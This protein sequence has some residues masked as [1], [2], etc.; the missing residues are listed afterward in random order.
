MRTTKERHALEVHDARQQDLAHRDVLRTLFLKNKS[1]LARKQVLERQAPTA[2]NG[3]DFPGRNPTRLLRPHPLGCRW[4]ALVRVT[5]QELAGHG[6]SVNPEMI[7]R[8]V[9]SEPQFLRR[10]VEIVLEIAP[11]G[12]D[13]LLC[14]AVEV[15]ENR[16]VDL[17]NALGSQCGRGVRRTF[18]QATFLV[19]ATAP[20]GAGIVAAGLGPFLHV[21][22]GRLRPKI[23]HRFRTVRWS[24]RDRRDGLRCS[25]AVIGRSRAQVRNCQTRPV[26][27]AYRRI[28]AGLQHRA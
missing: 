18:C 1:F 7:D 28:G 6:R 10:I 3:G 23:P 26:P 22:S 25:P 21:Q 13:L 27:S 24:C 19:L 5:L 4:A 14:K 9:A 2:L 16:V 17:M 20:A 8:P 12:A 15:M 11:F